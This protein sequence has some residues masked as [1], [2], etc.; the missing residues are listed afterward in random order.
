MSAAEA[1][2][3]PSP[4]GCQQSFLKADADR[5]LD[6]A[7]ETVK[8]EYLRNP[9]IK[10]RAPAVFAEVHAHT[11]QRPVIGGTAVYSNLWAQLQVAREAEGADEEEAER[12]EEAL[13]S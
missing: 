10:V 7:Y 6:E 8:E 2:A 11:T 5:L 13:S 9:D 4:E 12:A 1:E 3:E